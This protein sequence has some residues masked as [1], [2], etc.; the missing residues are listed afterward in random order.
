MGSLKFKTMGNATVQLWEGDKPI[1]TTDPWLVGRAYFDSWA[2][3]H[4][5]SDAEIESAKN[6]DYL[7]ISHGHP[8]HLHWESLALMPK[9]KK[10]FVPNHYHDEISELLRNEGFDVE[11]MEYRRWYRLSENLEILCIDNINQ[12]AI[13]VMRF[14]DA[15]LINLNDSPLCGERNFF[16]SL[17]SAHPNDKIYIFKLIGVAAD[18]LN[19]VDSDGKFITDPPEQY[20]PGCIQSAAAQIADLGGRHYCASSSQHIY[21]RADSRWA[22]AYDMN[23]FD[24][25]KYWNQPSVRVIE[26]FVTV[27]LETGERALDWPSLKADESQMLEGTGPDDWSEKLTEE[28]WQ[29]VTAF[30]QQFETVK[31]IVDFIDLD[32]GGER[33]RVFGGEAPKWRKPRGVRFMVPRYSLLETVQ[34]GYFDD[35]LIGN[36]M[37]TELI[38]MRLYP[39]FSPRIAKYGGNAK[40]Y[41]NKSLKA[42]YRHYFWRN[43]IGVAGFWLQ[44]YWQVKVVRDMSDLTERLGI[45]PPIKW[46][47]NKARRL[48]A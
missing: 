27:D 16:R 45:K 20:K 26:P 6:S 2:L 34:W 38:N 31:D 9:G 10:V 42:M 37:K 8:D 15:L 5:M 17:T 18:M 12:D 47:Y 28:E 23:H 40:V 19:Y 7:W 21:A 1:L 41:D 25:V 43:P 4:P 24:M 3:H 44:N 29:R 30:F 22:N 11:V 13:L 39:D 33:R 32:V 36:F 46:L 48:V 14:G 35:L